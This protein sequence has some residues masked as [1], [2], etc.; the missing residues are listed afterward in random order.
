MQAIDRIQVD[1]FFDLLEKGE[2][3]VGETKTIYI[4]AG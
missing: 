4:F 2:E 1:V 3:V